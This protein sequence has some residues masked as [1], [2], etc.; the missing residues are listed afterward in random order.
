MKKI[1]SF[2]VDPPTKSLVSESWYLMSRQ[3]MI[4][5]LQTNEQV[6]LARVHC[7]GVLQDSDRKLYCGGGGVYNNTP[8][9]CS[10]PGV[11]L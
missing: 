4:C 7:S 9:L 10:V 2:C 6:F 5:H 3:P 1:E 8:L 11:I